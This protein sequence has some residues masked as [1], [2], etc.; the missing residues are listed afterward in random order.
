M[1]VQDRLRLI[2][3]MKNHRDHYKLTGD[4]SGR[5]PDSCGGMRDQTAESNEESMSTRSPTTKVMAKV[6]D[7]EYNKYG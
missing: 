1:P 6:S 3:R 5:S 4:E 7:I 2:F